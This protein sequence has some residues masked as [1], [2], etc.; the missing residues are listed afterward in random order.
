MTTITSAT[1]IYERL[2]NDSAAISPA[3]RDE[4]PKLRVP[5]LFWAGVVVFAANLLVLSGIWLSPELRVNMYG[6]DAV[7]SRAAYV[8]PSPFTETVQLAKA[9]NP[10]RPEKLRPVLFQEPPVDPTESAEL[11]LPQGAQSSTAALAASSSLT[12]HRPEQPVGGERAYRA[13]ESYPDLPR[14]TAS[15]HTS[16][17]AESVRVR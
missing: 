4:E 16:R 2:D 7:H 9:A 6:E 14:V 13:A 5:A 11:L 8:R 1:Y 15:L 10:K 3:A 17:V 12:V